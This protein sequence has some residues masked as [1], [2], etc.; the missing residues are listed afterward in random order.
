MLQLCLLSLNARS[1]LDKLDELDILMSQDRHGCDITETSIRSLADH[2][3]V[4]QRSYQIYR[5]DRSFHS[6]GVVVTIK[7]NIHSMPPTRSP[8]FNLFLKVSI[9]KVCFQINYAIVF[10]KYVTTLYE[11]TFNLP[12]VCWDSLHHGYPSPYNSVLDIT[13]S[14]SSTTSTPKQGESPKLNVSKSSILEFLLVS[15]ILKLAIINQIPLI[16]QLNMKLQTLTIVMQKI[17]G[18]IS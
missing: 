8:N 3:G 18:K 2:D 6:G 1:I 4:T 14:Q 7:A 13:I 12:S 16:D 9:Y 15:Q 10:W 17:C 11:A 5:H